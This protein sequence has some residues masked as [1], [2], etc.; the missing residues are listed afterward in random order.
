[1]HRTILFLTEVMIIWKSLF[2]CKNSTH[3]IFQSRYLNITEG[4]LFGK[5]ALQ[6][7]W[8]LIILYLLLTMFNSSYVGILKKKSFQ[9]YEQNSEW[10]RCRKS[11]FLVQCCPLNSKKIPFSKSPHKNCWNSWDDYNLQ[12]SRW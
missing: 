7:T 2:A 3:K 6:K 11:E 12:V 10:A 5:T 8:N 9:Y 1:M 4:A